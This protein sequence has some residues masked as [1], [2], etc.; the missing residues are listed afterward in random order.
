MPQYK[1]FRKKNRYKTL[2]YTHKNKR[3]NSHKNKYRVGSGPIMRFVNR[4][5]PRARTH[6]VPDPGGPPPRRAE[7][8][9]AAMVARMH[10]FLAEEERRLQRDEEAPSEVPPLPRS[11][12]RRSRAP[13][14]RVL[15]PEIERE[16]RI[17]SLLEETRQLLIQLDI[18][19]ATTMDI[20]HDRRFFYT[21]AAMQ[22]LEHETDVLIAKLESPDINHDYRIANAR[23]D[24]FI[25][26]ETTARHVQSIRDA[27][28]HFATIQ[29]SNRIR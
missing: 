1:S 5:R 18:I 7:P 26:L 13:P 27:M 16:M 20:R 3:K 22:T 29:Y 2:K 12:R 21:E 6:S 11:R 10:T 9:D 28:D 19:H 23:S 15:D 8:I 4:L 24:L 25:K 17:E 14:P